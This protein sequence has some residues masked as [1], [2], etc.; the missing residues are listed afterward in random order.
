MLER[1]CF[2]RVICRRVKCSVF[3]SSVGVSGGENQ[4]IQIA[5]ADDV[6]TCVNGFPFFFLLVLKFVIVL[7]FWV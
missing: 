5:F 2:V 4:S 3:S 7:R 6:V 1:E